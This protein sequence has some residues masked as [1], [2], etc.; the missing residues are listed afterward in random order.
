METGK[1]SVLV[2]SQFA[3]L[4]L[5]LYPLKLRARKLTLEDRNVCYSYVGSSN[6]LS[7]CHND[8]INMS[9]FLVAQQG[10]VFLLAFAQKFQKSKLIK[11]RESERAGIEWRI[12]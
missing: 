4:T 2:S 12:S 10:L 3:P 7:G 9:K 6:A 11:G 5:L 8:A 1:L